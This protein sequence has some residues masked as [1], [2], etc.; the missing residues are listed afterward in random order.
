MMKRATMMFALCLV[1]AT[2][3]GETT[4]RQTGEGQ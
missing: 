4:V 1:V 3:W 2:A